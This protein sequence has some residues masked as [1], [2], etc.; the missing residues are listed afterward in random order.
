MADIEKLVSLYEQNHFR[1]EMLMENVKTFFEKNPELHQGS[2]PAV[3]SVK[4]RMKSVDHF[5][6]KLQRKQDAGIDETNLFQKVTDFAG[7][8]VLHIYQQQFAEIHA[9]IMKQ[10]EAGEWVLGEDVVAY[11]WDPEAKVF[12][13]KLGIGTKLKDTYYTS[14]HY[15]LKP[16]R[17]SPFC[18]EVQVRTLFEEIWGEIDHTINY[19]HPIE[20]VA[21]VEEL[22]V[23]SK[24]ISAGTRLADAIFRTHEAFM[25]RNGK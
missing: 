15:L 12:F 7:V 2:L 1:I 9:A 5:R 10:V 4:A 11:S 22:R 19:P 24:Y 8:R 6:D 14:V 13:E 3:H 16:H 20:D 18:C 23:L 21:C 17:D 25:L